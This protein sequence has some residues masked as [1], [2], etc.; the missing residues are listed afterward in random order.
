MKSENFKEK[1]KLSQA[2]LGLEKTKVESERI[3]VE[4]SKER[5]NFSREYFEKTG[6][7]LPKDY[8]QLISSQRNFKTLLIGKMTFGE[9]LC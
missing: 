6:N 8:F 2:R 9:F 1:L 4:S 5:L 7:I 3:R